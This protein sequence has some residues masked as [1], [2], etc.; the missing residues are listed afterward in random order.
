MR[1]E[2]QSWCAIWAAVRSSDEDIGSADW[3]GSRPTLSGPT[4]HQF[5]YD[6]WLQSC[7]RVLANCTHTSYSY[8]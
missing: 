2:R 8:Y 5:E 1:F 7:V 3:A 6:F 4:F